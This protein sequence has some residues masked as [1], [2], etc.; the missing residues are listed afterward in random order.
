MMQKIYNFFKE[1]KEKGQSII[2]YGIL[3]AVVVTAIVTVRGSFKMED[4]LEKVTNAI[5]AQMTKAGT[6]ISADISDDGNDG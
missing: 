6:N 2:E 4:Q 1:K 5:S 3:L